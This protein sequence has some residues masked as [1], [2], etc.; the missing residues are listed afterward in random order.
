[1]HTE[2]VEN[3]RNET[4][5]SYVCLVKMNPLKG[6][7][8]KKKTQLNL[9]RDAVKLWRWDKWLHARVISTAITKAPSCRDVN[10]FDEFD[11]GI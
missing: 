1:M 9:S 4:K 3:G 10:E 5:Y 11:D 2:S 7:R 8:R 6:N